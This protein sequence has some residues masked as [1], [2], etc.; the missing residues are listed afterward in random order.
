MSLLALIPA[1]V[2]AAAAALPLPADLLDGY[3]RGEAATG[4]VFSRGWSA[5]DRAGVCAL[6]PAALSE[7]E[8]RLGRRLGRPFTTVLAADRYGLERLADRLGIELRDPGAVL[9]L[10]VPGY[11]LLLLRE[12]NLPGHGSFRATLAHEVAHL[13]IHRDPRATV[14][15]WFDEGAAQWVAGQRL[16][17]DDE[18]YLSLLARI[19]ALYP[20]RRLATSFPSGLETTSTAYRQSLLLMEF[21]LQ[22]RGPEVLPRL[23]DLFEGGAGTTAALEAVLGSPLETIE[24]DFGAYAAARSSWLLAVSSVIGLWTVISLLALVAVVLHLVRR[25]RRMREMAR[26][27]AREETREE[28]RED[29]REEAREDAPGMAREDNGGR[30]P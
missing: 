10:A 15:R 28:A 11:E 18:A 20:L 19:G 21:L 13:I 24:R 5:E 25:Q 14:P 1:M 29:A 8:D 22:R 6:L 23:L 2:L 3:D 12:G 26:E 7:A 27:E 30:G 17:P 16:S 4:P 9:G